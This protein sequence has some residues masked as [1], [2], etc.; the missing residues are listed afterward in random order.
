MTVHNAKWRVFD[1]WCQENV[2]DS[3]NALP[4]QLADFFLFLHEVKNLATVTIRGYRSAIARVYRLCQLP[5]PG[6]NQELSALFSN[7]GLE[8]RR[9]TRLFPK[10]SLDVV[11]DFLQTE[12]FEPLESTCMRNLS[13]KTVFLLTLA[14]AGLVSEIHALSLSLSVCVSTRM[15]PLR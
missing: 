12:R 13:L 14:T 9:V 11:L 10:W 8:R 15:A 7:F 4:G 3:L 2:V 1:S 5:D 6:A